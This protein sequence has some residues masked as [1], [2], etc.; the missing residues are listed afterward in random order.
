M[1]LSWEEVVRRAQRKDASAFAQ[2]I[3]RHERAALAVAFG[4]LND[5]NAAGDAVQEAFVRAWER[6]ADLKE[7]GRFGPWLCGIVRNLAIDSLRR[8]RNEAR[9]GYDGPAAEDGRRDKRHPD[10]GYCPDPSDELSRRERHDAVAAALQALDEVSRSAVVLR[11]YDGLSSKQIGELL[12]LAPAA[13]D[14]R[15]TRARRVLRE[16]LGPAELSPGVGRQ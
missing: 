10:H 5:G 6:L 11:Y 1:E 7:P 13:V 8:S 16:R 2:L 3:G 15:L 12:D 9:P 4:V 14:M